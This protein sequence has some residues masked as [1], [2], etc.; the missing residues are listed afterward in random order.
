MPRTS[1]QSTVPIDCLQLTSNKTFETV[2]D[3]C[4]SVSRL[5]DT[6]NYPYQ[7]TDAAL[8]SLK[9]DIRMHPLHICRELCLTVILKRLAL[10]LFSLKPR[11][12][13]S[14]RKGTCYPGM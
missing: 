10:N 7:N 9:N 11:M 14:E 1:S 8:L 2:Q 5:N 6:T 3:T 12:R 4:P 13:D